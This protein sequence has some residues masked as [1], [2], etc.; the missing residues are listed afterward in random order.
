VRIWHL[1]HGVAQRVADDLAHRAQ[2]VRD[3]AT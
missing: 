3:Q 2:Q 1:E